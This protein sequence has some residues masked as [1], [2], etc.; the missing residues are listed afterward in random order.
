MPKDMWATHPLMSCTCRM[1]EALSGTSKN[2]KENN[3]IF[4]VSFSLSLKLIA[5]LS[6]IKDK[7]NSDSYLYQILK[8]SVKPT[9]GN[10][11]NVQHLTVK[12]KCNCLRLYDYW[13]RDKNYM[14]KWSN[15]QNYCI[16]ETFLTL[17]YRLVNQTIFQVGRTTSQKKYAWIYISKIYLQHSN[18]LSMVSLQVISQAKL[19]MIGIFP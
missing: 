3:I 7:Q 12:Q 19:G 1:L 8:A 14:G 4:A 17:W 2:Q 5:K 9:R 6:S 16:T 13:H 18:F 10:K 11:E 15:R